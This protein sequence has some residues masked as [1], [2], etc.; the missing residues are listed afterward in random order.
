MDID[1]TIM[2]SKLDE[3]PL[4]F[5]LLAKEG[6]QKELNQHNPFPVLDPDKIYVNIARET[7]VSS[8]TLTESLLKKSI[9]AENLLSNNLAGMYSNATD[10][11]TEA[12]IKGLNAT[13]VKNSIDHLSAKL[14]NT[15]YKQI[16]DFWKTEKLSIPQELQVYSINSFLNTLEQN[17]SLVER[18]HQLDSSYPNLKQT[19]ISYFCKKLKDLYGKDIHPD[20][21]QVLLFKESDT[22]LPFLS[23]NLTNFILDYFLFY[24]LANTITIQIETNQDIKNVDPKDLLHASDILAIKSAYQIKLNDFWQKNFHNYRILT[25]FSYLRALLG[26]Q[27]SE[28]KLSQKGFELALLAMGFSQE[29]LDMVNALDPKD[30][31]LDIL[32]KLSNPNHVQI[33]SF[34]FNNQA[35]SDILKICDPETD[36]ILL[37]I[38]GY[39]PSFIEAK[40]ER[41]LIHWVYHQIELSPDNLAKIASHFPHAARMANNSKLDAFLY[42]DYVK[43]GNPIP[44]TTQGDIFSFITERQQARMVADL[45]VLSIPMNFHPFF[46]SN[47]QSTDTSLF[48]TVVAAIEC[49]PY[50]LPNIY[51]I[52]C[53][54]HELFPNPYK[55]AAELVKKSIKDT[56]AL[57]IDPDKTFIQVSSSQVQSIG[58]DPMVPPILGGGSKKSIQSLTEAVLSNYR[59]ESSF[60]GFTKTVIYQSLSGNA[61]YTADDQLLDILPHDIE[62]IIQEANLDTLHKNKLNAFW[63]THADRMKY[64]IKQ[65]Y[66][67]Q[68]LEEYQN[69]TLSEE[70]LKILL[71]VTLY[72]LSKEEDSSDFIYSNTSIEIISIA[73]YQSTD[74]FIFRNS[75]QKRVILYIP[76]N[77]KTFFAFASYEKCICFLEENAK[78]SP[79]WQ[80]LLLS[81]FSMDVQDLVLDALKQGPYMESF[82]L[83]TAP[84]QRPTDCSFKNAS[85]KHPIT[86]KPI[87]KSLF[88]AIKKNIQERSYVDANTLITSNRLL[89]QLILFTHI[90]PIINSCN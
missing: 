9:G 21:I 26:Q 55:T 53:D 10:V 62:I 80:E 51:D 41:L 87:E 79:Q 50:L 56:L 7:T 12:Q 49:L 38:P 61:E 13:D 35:S 58:Y 76:E 25:K 32:E 31:P 39:A 84:Y 52:S 68:I 47:N 48:T 44:I 72:S 30:I 28:M 45:Y 86:I 2:K 37:Y 8:E 33:S 11:N 82:T 83:A 54:L 75:D 27:N 66:L 29:K 4:S 81:H 23:F 34:L 90:I 6:L 18:A 1:L 57:D 22:H 19:I 64:F 85:I 16:N 24:L 78:E 71:D 65:R 59:H 5:K 63:N 3:I 46:T 67:Q 74:L 36:D 17:F 60:Y 69:N 42:S 20:T 15:Y 89:A 70:D 14:I 77:T 88:E 43:Q 40:D 73:E